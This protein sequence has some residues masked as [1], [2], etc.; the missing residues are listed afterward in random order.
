MGSMLF[1]EA[2]QKFWVL[3]LYVCFVCVHYTRT[4][5]LPTGY[6]VCYQLFHF[7]FQITCLHLLLSTTM[8]QRTAWNIKRDLPVSH[9]CTSTYCLKPPLQILDLSS[10]LIWGL[11]SQL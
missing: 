5:H 6:I 1:H 10:L 11:V 9:S 7:I 2:F 3:K 4:F 8:K